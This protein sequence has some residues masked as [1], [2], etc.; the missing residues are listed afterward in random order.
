MFRGML[1]K[2]LRLNVSRWEIMVSHRILTEKHHGVVL[3]AEPIPTAD[4]DKEIIL[5]RQGWPGP[6]PVFFDDFDLCA[7]V[8]LA[9]MDISFR[10]RL[11]DAS[12]PNP[13]VGVPRLAALLI[14]PPDESPIFNQV[15]EENLGNLNTFIRVN[16]II[17]HL[18]DFHI[19]R[20]V[21]PSVFPCNGG[22]LDTPGTTFK[23][24]SQPELIKLVQTDP[25][26]AQRLREAHAL[27]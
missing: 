22:Y 21:Q 7:V 20:W 19:S 11:F 25:A 18:E 24:F 1:R 12:D 16:G 27:E 14:N 10:Q 8:G 6:V 13:A 4:D 3:P 9:A 23:Y 2:Q 17:G 26:V 15:S 5:I